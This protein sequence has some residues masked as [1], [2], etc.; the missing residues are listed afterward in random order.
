MHTRSEIRH[1]CYRMKKGAATAKNLEVV[2][3]VEP[4]LAEHQTW[5]KFAIEW[6]IM[7]GTG[8]QIVVIKPELDE[9]YVHQTCLEMKLLSQKGLDTAGLD[10]RQL[11]IIHIV[12]SLMLDGI[13]QWQNYNSA[14]GTKVN[15]EALMIETFLKNT[16]MGQKPVTDDMIQGSMQAFPVADNPDRNTTTTVNV[17]E[18]TEMSPEEIEKFQAV[19]DMMK[20]K[21]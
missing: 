10:D 15:R 19:L 4:L 12:E 14:W 9:L 13:M 5:N 1:S 2:A 3:L 16:N 21:G 17:G 11:N 8:G 7:I 18:F 20:K 6:D